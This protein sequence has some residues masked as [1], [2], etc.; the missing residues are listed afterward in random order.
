MEL[1]EELNTFIL[2]FLFLLRPRILTEDTQRVY[3][4]IVAYRLIPANN[5][6][7]NLANAIRK[8]L[9]LTISTKKE[10]NPA[11]SGRI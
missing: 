3:M 5:I 4:C 11:I 2:T 10:R 8:S 1:F 7:T 6:H 9:H